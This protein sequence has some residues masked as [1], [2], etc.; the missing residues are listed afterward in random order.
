[1][2]F[3]SYIL[4][5]ASDLVYKNQYSKWKS[6]ADECL[7]MYSLGRPVLIGTTSVEKSEL[8]SQI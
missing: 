5:I 8:V 2:T 7:E 4:S 3:I 1:M 6:V